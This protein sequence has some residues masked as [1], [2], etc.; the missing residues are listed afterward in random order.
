MYRLQHACNQFFIADA[1]DLAKVQQLRKR[2]HEHAWDAIQ[3]HQTRR[4][5]MVIPT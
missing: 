4:R 2:V 3:S 1:V 5:E